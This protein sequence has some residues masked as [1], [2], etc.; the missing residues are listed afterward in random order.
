MGETKQSYQKVSCTCQDCGKA[1]WAYGEE[2]QVDHKEPLFL[3][4]KD[5][6]YWA[7][8]NLSLLCKPCHARKTVVDMELYRKIADRRNYRS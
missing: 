2:W 6:S 1:T 7:K 4:E 5:L 8:E 3:A